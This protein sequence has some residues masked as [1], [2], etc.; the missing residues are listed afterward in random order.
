MAE[1]AQIIKLGDA[2]IITVP[3]VGELRPPWSVFNG[4]VGVFNGDK[5]NTYF[6]V[7]LYSYKVQAED[8]SNEVNAALEYIWRKLVDRGATSSPMPEVIRG[9][10]LDMLPKPA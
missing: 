7:T 2:Y 5:D 6:I 9:N 8:Q 1:N 10:P 4:D 3:R